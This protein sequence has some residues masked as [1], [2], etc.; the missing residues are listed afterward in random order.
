[1]ETMADRPRILVIYTSWSG[2]TESL[3]RAIAEGASEAGNRNV[4]VELK[5]ARDVGQADVEGASAMAF[6]SPTY[7]SYMSGEM[8]TLFDNALRYRD[9]FYGKPVI[10]FATG[11]G[12]QLKC[13]QSIEA[14][15]EFFEAL[16][17]Q[18]SDILS[19]GLAVQGR[20]DEGALR[21]AKAAGMKLGDAG[22][23][24]LCSMRSRNIIV[25]GRR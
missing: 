2:N 24:Y 4:E 18:K 14:I 3:A 20:P 1:M 23:G 7:Y 21:Q 8:K 11:N 10:A 19:A 22:V 5:R 12:G 25:G 15:L 6:G 9:A 13:I 16:F 17:I